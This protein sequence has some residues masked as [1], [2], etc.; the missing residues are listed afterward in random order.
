MDDVWEGFNRVVAHV[1]TFRMLLS[2]QVAASTYI[3]YE[4][5]SALT[6]DIFT[7]SSI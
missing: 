4:E 3:Q 2:R 7:R 1:V 5:T 6:V